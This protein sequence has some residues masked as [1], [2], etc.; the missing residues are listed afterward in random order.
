MGKY[1]IEL[2]KGDNRT[3]LEICDTK[4]YAME[5]G[6]KYRGDYTR[7][8]GVIGCIFSNVDRDGNVDT[9]RYKIIHC[10]D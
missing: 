6:L 1:V 7:E 2:I 10:W 8:E 4:E 9:S 3:V 5:R